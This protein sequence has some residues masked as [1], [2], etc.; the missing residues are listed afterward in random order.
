MPENIL[1]EEK[2]LNLIRKKGTFVSNSAQEKTTVKKFFSLNLL[3]YLP[4]LSL[5]KIIWGIFILAIV[6]LGIS[7]IYPF[8]GLRKIKLPHLIQLDNVV[9]KNEIKQEAKPFDFYKKA[10]GERQIFTSQNTPETSR[11]T[12]AINAELTKD[13]NLVGIVAGD[14]PQAII[15][16]KKTQKAYYVSKGQFIGEF[17]VDDIGEGKVI[18]DYAGQKFELYL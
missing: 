1:P 5:Q 6:F 15:E 7:L 10:A 12:G 11:L 16:D 8:F 14:N 18:L 17:R 3:Q 4:F 13:I 2:L 9:P